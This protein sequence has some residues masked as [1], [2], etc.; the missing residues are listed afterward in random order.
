MRQRVEAARAGTRNREH[1]RG[2]YQRR[3][4]FVRST[5]IVCWLCGEGWRSDDPWQADHIEP[6]NPSSELA[7]AHRSCNIA[8]SNQSRARH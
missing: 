3:A 1:Y 8:R 6:G 4:K 5:A 7:A 2:D